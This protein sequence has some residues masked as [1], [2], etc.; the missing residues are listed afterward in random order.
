MIWRIINLVLVFI[1]GLLVGVW[2]NKEINPIPP[3]QLIEIIKDSII[4]DSIF[5][6]NEVIKTKIKYIEKEHDEEI[7]DI[8]SNDDS[9]NLEFFSRYIEDY[10]QSIKNR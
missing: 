7:S 1:F 3:P 10:E 9:T 4:R 2:L 5:I 8:M 6:E